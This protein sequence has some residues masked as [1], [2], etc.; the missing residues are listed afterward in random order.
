MLKWD[1]NG[2]SVSKESINRIVPYPIKFSV[3]EDEPRTQF[4]IYNS[5]VPFLIKFPEGKVSMASAS[6]AAFS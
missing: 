6:D 2:V 5:L 1:E 4:Q 3:E